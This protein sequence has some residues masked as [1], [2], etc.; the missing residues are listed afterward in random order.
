MHENEIG[1]IVVDQAIRLH[2]ELG[3]GLMESVY[4][5]L[6]A[7]RLQMA[8]LKV[9]C[10][11]P[12]AFCFDGITFDQ[13]FRADMIIE[14]KVILELK[15]VESLNHAH[16]KQILTYLKLS[17]LKLGFLLNFGEAVMKNGIHR[18]INGQL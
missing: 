4:E 3:P 10:Q 12:I 9:E 14:D 7:H 1:K 18:I 8:G 13:G 16:Y 15:S 5:T 11:V 2:K 17:G 6:L